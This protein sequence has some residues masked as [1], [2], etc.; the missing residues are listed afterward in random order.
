MRPSVLGLMG[1]KKQRIFLPES[2]ANGGILISV[3][4]VYVCLIEESGMLLGRINPLKQKKMNV[5]KAG[6]RF[7]EPSLK[8]YTKSHTKKKKNFLGRLNQGN[9][10]LSS[11]HPPF[12]PLTRRPSPR[13]WRPFV[14]PRCLGC[15]LSSQPHQ[16]ATRS[17]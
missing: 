6:K 16:I 8:R 9:H 13:C 2:W 15:T 10:S 12:H 5:F 1:Q 14:V 17:I 3:S 4:L 11:F 7:K